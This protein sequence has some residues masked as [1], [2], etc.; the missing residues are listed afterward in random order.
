MF[1]PRLK[2]ALCTLRPLREEEAETIVPWWEDLETTRTI[3][4]RLPVGLAEERDWLAAAARDPNRFTWG[5]EC[6]GRLVGISG[7]DQIDWLNARAVTGTV[8]GD[9]S[10]RGKGIGS[11]SMWLRTEFVFTQTQLHKLCSGYLSNNPASGRA[12]AKSGYREVGRR[13]EHFFRDGEWVDEIV[14][15]VLRADW[16]ALAPPPGFSRNSG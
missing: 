15:E 12:Q 9:P 10:A 3:G 8:V 11:E 7:V 5:I 16:A 13:R 1:G 14:T 4:R 2:G 6:E